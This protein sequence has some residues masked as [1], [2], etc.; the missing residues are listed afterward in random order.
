MVEQ[1]KYCVKKT[2]GIWVDTKPRTITY[3]LSLF[4]FCH[5]KLSEQLQPLDMIDVTDIFLYLCYH[6]RHHCTVVQTSLYDCTVMLM[7]D[8]DV[9][10]PVCAG[11]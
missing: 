7:Y 6:H 5:D 4:I 8:N 11:E 1:I 10:T 2:E 3:V 9:L